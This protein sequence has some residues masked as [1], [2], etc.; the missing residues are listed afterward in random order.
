GP[1]LYLYVAD[2]PLDRL[3]PTGMAD[4]GSNIPCDYVCS[5]TA[6]FARNSFV[7]APFATNVASSAARIAIKST[8]VAAAIPAAA[9]AII[10]AVVA[11]S[12]ASDDTLTGKVYRLHGGISG[13][14]GHSWTT[15]DPRTMSNPRDSLG[16]PDG[17]TATTLSIGRLVDPKGVVLRPAEPLHGNRGGAPELIVPEPATQIQDIRQEPFKELNR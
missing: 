15:V 10:N 17:N 11:S 5:W 13:P 9:G 4:S 8:A 7:S 6:K 1:N 2:D 16:L 12:T 3:D 14:L